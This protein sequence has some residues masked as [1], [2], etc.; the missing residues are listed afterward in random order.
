[1]IHERK[2]KMRPF[3]LT[4]NFDGS[5]DMDLYSVDGNQPE[6]WLMCSETEYE[7]EIPDGYEIDTDKPVEVSLNFNFSIRKKNRN[8]F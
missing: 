5:F 4:R 8:A 6:G 3:G 7:L 2:F 1:M